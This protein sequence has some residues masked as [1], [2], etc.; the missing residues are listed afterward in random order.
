MS[1]F[2]G[3]DQ[4]GVDRQMAPGFWGDEWGLWGEPG[5]A[6]SCSTDTA[7]T[8]VSS[9]P[10]GLIKHLVHPR[11]AIAAAALGWGGAPETAKKAKTVREK[12]WAVQKLRGEAEK[13]WDELV[14]W[15]SCL[16]FFWMLYVGGHCQCL[17]RDTTAL[18]VPKG[19][20][21]LWTLPCT[22]D[23]GRSGTATNWVFPSGACSWN[24]IARLLLVKIKVFLWESL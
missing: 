9:W 24:L 4:A 10:K 14:T 22:E 7:S 18:C 21:T 3:C 20:Q 19:N 2:G 5:A 11:W 1:S 23:C 16:E 17:R 12:I 15:K 13:H 8:A 6:E